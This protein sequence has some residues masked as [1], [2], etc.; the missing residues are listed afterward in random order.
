[1]YAYSV[2]TTKTNTAILV[3]IQ[4]TISAIL[5]KVKKISYTKQSNK[6]SYAKQSKKSAI[7]N[8]VTKLAILNKVKNQLYKTK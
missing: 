6:I 1:M 3:Q 2:A 7:Q 4:V 5:N 8:K